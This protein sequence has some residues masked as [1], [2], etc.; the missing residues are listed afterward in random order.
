MKNRG[1]TTGSLMAVLP[2]PGSPAYQIVQP[3]KEV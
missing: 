1:L 3:G 2:F